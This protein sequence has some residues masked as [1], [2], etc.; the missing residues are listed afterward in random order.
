[1]TAITRYPLPAPPLTKM[2]NMHRSTVGFGN[3]EQSI[4]DAHTVRCR[5]DHRLHTKDGRSTLMLPTGF[6]HKIIKD[7]KLVS[8]LHP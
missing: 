6:G 8:K 4:L 2:M 5:W 7:S 3:W 1:M